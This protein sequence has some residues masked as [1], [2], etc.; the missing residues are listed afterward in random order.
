[1]STLV[2]DMT[3]IEPTSGSKTSRKV[4]PHD[5]ECDHEIEG[6][7]TPILLTALAIGFTSSINY[8]NHAPLVPALISQFHFSQTFAGFLAT[9]LFLSHAVMQIPGGHL[10]DRFGPRPVLFAALTILCIGNCGIVFSIDYW[11]LLFWKIF[12]GI[13]TGIC[14]VGGVRCLATSFSGTRLQVVQGYFGGSILLGSG[15]AIFVIPQVL[16]TI[17]W[18]CTFISTGLIAAAVLV[19]LLIAVPP[20]K[21]IVH[22]E[23]GFKD[24]FRSPQ[25]WLLGLM[26]MASLGLV[27]IVGTWIALLLQQ[28][29][30]LPVRE[31]GIL[32]S[33][34]LLLGI[35]SRPLGGFVA[36]SIGVRPL[37]VTSFVMT[38]L[39]CFLLAAVASY[40]SSMVGIVLIGSGC[41]LPFATLFKR[42]AALF[43]SCAGA[44]MGLVNMM[45][46]AMIV[47]GAPLAGYA[48][49]LSGSYRLSF[50][51]LGLFSLTVG[52][53]SF[54]I[55]D[56]LRGR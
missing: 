30:G 1:L 43:P 52:A 19:P 37:L 26:H 55:H 7:R 47:V 35:I 56:E 36:A 48:A 49:Q 3:R 16:T 53:I 33:M 25:L 50:R 15:F 39:G 40:T 41:G 27:I 29:L 4:L 38:A 22:S 32:G 42:A 12:I 44:A 11:H 28:N 10:A 34:P 23:G 8:T 45:G 9:G 24:V 51:A 6:R 31:A 21:I 18:R 54:L 46:I 13:G 20:K 14:F 17:G 5:Y 2:I